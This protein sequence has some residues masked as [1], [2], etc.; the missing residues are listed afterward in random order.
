M[1]LVALGSNISGP[2]G[3]PTQTVAHALRAL[4][5]GGLRLIKA[6]R[7]MLTAPFGR[8]NQPDFVNAVVRIETH[9]PPI[10]RAVEVYG[11]TLERY[12]SVRRVAGNRAC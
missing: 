5:T 10:H 9:L 4:D 1:K 11:T 12:V 6:S 2:W 8:P 3:T 7:L